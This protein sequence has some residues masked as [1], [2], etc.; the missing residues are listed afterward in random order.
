MLHNVHEICYIIYAICYIMYYT[1]NML[2]DICYMQ[3]WNSYIECI[4]VAAA[5]VV[6]VVVV[7][8]VVAAAHKLSV[9]IS[10]RPNPI[11]M[12]TAAIGALGITGITLA[13]A[14]LNPD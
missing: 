6:V 14:I 9:R 13:S 8:V 11:A 1:W 3:H 5:L 10:P 7:V 4:W 12:H 2:Y